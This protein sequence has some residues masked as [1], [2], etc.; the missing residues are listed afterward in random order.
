MK[1]KLL[2]IIANLTYYPRIALDWLLFLYVKNNNNPSFLDKISNKDCLIVGNGP[3][4]KITPLDKISRP[5]IGMNKINLLFDKTTWRPDII[6]CVN[7][8][9]IKQNLF[10]LNS[11]H[12]PL[13]L[14][15]KSIYLGVKKRPN[16]YFILQSNLINFSNTIDKPIGI[17]STVTYACFQVAAWAKVKSISLVGV[18]HSFQFSGKKHDIQMQIEDDN[19]HFDS[20]YFK[21]NLWGLPDLDGS[22]KAYLIAKSYFDNES[23]PVIDYTLNGKLN[24]FP[25]GNIND[26]IT[27]KNS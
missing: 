9:V 23:V 1:Y 4:L 20:N 16:V 10:F 24:I 14:P 12:I 11:T 8:L 5:S 3:S 15:V 25:K 13:V 26:L 7:S 27:Q 18:D 19:N 21:G 6:V 2:K 22:E 17:G